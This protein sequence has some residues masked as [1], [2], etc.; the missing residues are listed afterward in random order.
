MNKAFKFNN[1]NLDT[2]QSAIWTQREMMKAKTGW[3]ISKPRDALGTSFYLELF[4]SRSLEGT[5]LAPTPEPRH[6]PPELLNNIFDL[7]ASQLW[8]MATS[9]LGNSYGKPSEIQVTELMLYCD[10][11]IQHNFPSLSPKCS[12]FAARN[13][14]SPL[15]QSIQAW[16]KIWSR[17]VLLR[18]GSPVFILHKPVPSSV[19]DSRPEPRRDSSF[20]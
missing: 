18:S 16:L 13:S 9:T 14:S 7:E 3:C 1:G 5:S 15:P 11:E 17:T 2:G 4:P 8:D 20:S 19:L 6:Q 12:Q 10:L